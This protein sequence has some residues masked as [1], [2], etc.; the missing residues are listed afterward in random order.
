MKTPAI[1]W[2]SLKLILKNDQGQILGL[3][4]HPRGSFAGFY[5]LPGGTI[6]SQEFTA[7][8][9]TI[10]RREL[11]EELGSVE[12]KINPTPLGVGRHLIPS[13]MTSRK[14]GDVLILYVFFEGT[15][16]GGKITISDEH[17]GYAWLDLQ[18]NRPNLFFK[19]GLL[20]GLET[21]LKKSNP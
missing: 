14:T 2:V 9:E 16:L 11:N 7:N 10:L 1:F 8:Y 15:Y 18:K 17:S 20:E 3:N 4:G 13:S 12:V 6:D 19:S 5:D 21:Y